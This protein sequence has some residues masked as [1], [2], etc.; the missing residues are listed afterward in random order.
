VTAVDADPVAIA[1]A[2]ALASHSPVPVTF[3]AMNA[4]DLGRFRAE[5]FAMVVAIDFLHMISLEKRTRLA[6][7]VG[8]LLIPR[9]VFLIIDRVPLT[10]LLSQISGFRVED[11]DSPRSSFLVKMIE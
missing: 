9:G 1:R 8:Q 11:G 3:L 2:K 7:L 10:T 5:S 6:E 4:L